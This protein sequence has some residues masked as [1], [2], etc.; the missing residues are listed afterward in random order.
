MRLVGIDPGC[1]ATGWALVETKPMRI[2]D[3][4]TWRGGPEK[5][6]QL[7]MEWLDVHQVE[8]GI[9]YHVAIQVPGLWDGKWPRFY[10]GDKSGVGFA[11]HAMMAGWL[12]G[13]FSACGWEVVP[14]PSAEM[15]KKGP[16][17]PVALFRADW[18]YSGTPTSEHARDA[19]YIALW[20]ASS[21]LWQRSTYLFTRR[22]FGRWR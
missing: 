6:Q 1:G 16:K 8:R 18:S 22:G 2:L 9:E 20:G 5:I 12:C 11:K 4:G 15:R 21:L 14:C 19:A 17:L 13:M 3:I 10:A 7:T